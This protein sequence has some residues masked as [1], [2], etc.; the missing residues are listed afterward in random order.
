LSI[1]WHDIV[2]NPQINWDW[3]FIS[4]HPNI[5]WK[6]IQSNPNNPWCWACVCYNPNITLEIILQSPVLKP[7]LLNFLENK[8][9]TIKIFNQLHKENKDNKRKGY[10]DILKYIIKICGGDIIGC[11]MDGDA[12]DDAAACGH[13]NCLKLAYE[14]GGAPI[15]IETFYNAA[16]YGH[17]D[18]LQ[19]AINNEYEY[20]RNEHGKIMCEKAAKNGHINCLKFLR[21]EEM[22][23]DEQTCKSAAECA[24]KYNQV[25]CLEYAYKNGCPYSK[26]VLSIIVQKILIPKWRA[27]VKNRS[28][29]YYWMER[30]AQTSCAENGRARIEDKKSFENDFNN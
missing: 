13:L 25:E 9:I 2:S 10:F 14:F 27:Y 26:E 7:H 1:T 8:N 6:I 23:W 24:L 4:S 19:Y 30:S 20:D 5:T 29:V 22:H 12:C 21:E 3:S 16:E 18:C 17:V 28:I 11:N 15:G